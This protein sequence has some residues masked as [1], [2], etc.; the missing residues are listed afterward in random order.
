MDEFRMYNV[1]TLGGV[2]H[3]YAQKLYPQFYKVIAETDT[4]FKNLNNRY[5][6][7]LGFEVENH[8]LVHLTGASFKGN[9]LS[10][11]LNWPKNCQKSLTQK[12]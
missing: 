1:G 3:R 8:V 2:N 9:V 4:P 12:F 6:L 7:L 11:V 5:S 10:F